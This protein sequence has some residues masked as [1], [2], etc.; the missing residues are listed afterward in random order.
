MK[1]I[2]W[3][4]SYP[5]SGNTWFR[6][7][8]ANYRANADAPVPL[9]DISRFALGDSLATLYQRAAGPGARLNDERSVLQ[10]REPMLR[11]LIGTGQKLHFLKTHNQNTTVG[12]VELIPPRYTRAAIY[13]VRNPL[14]LVISYGAHYNLDTPT[15]AQAISSKV[16]Q[17]LEDRGNVRQYLGTWS[18]H[19]RSWAT[20]RRFPVH[21]IRYEDMLADPQATFQTAMTKLGFD[22]DA[23][24]LARAIE[25]S[26]F[27]SVRKQEETDG[28]IEKSPTAEFFFRKGQS[29][30]WQDTLDQATV[31]MIR[32]EHRKTM[33]KFGY[34]PK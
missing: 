34:L 23:D 31:D 28:F 25:F 22:V 12:G 3:L 26:S 6:L 8:L 2:A 17:I 1:C 4:A 21:V 32:S 33:Q 9:N 16:N 30:Q 18:Q 14:D 24:R 20:E 15:A 13:I 29:G 5:K 7:V 19:V 27:K 10:T 11:G